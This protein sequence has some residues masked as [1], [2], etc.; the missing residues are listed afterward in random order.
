MNSDLTSR[1]FEMPELGRLWV[2][3]QSADAHKASCDTDRI[4]RAD[5]S[6]TGVIGEIVSEPS[7]QNI[8]PVIADL[9]F[10]AWK[11]EALRRGRDWLNFVASA[12]SEEGIREVFADLGAA[13]DSLEEVP[14]EKC[15]ADTH[16]RA[17]QK[18]EDTY[19][20]R[21]RGDAIGI[22]TGL[23]TLDRC[24]SG[25]FKPGELVTIGAL[26]GKGKTHIG[27]S[28][29]MNAIRSGF[30]ACY[31]TI[32]M[33]DIAIM[34]RMIAHQSGVNSKILTAGGFDDYRIDEQMDAV[35]RS[36]EP[37]MKK[38]LTIADETAG[39]YENLEALVRRLVRL[40]KLDILVI[41]Y[42]QQFYFAKP[43][44]NRVAELNLIT[45]KVKH[46]TKKYNFSTV[47]LAQ[48]NREAQ[49]EK[50]RGK[51]HGSHQF[52]QSHSIAK[53]SDIILIL[54]EDAIDGQ[55]FLYLSKNR[56]GE[57]GLRLPV[58][59]DRRVSRIMEVVK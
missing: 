54:D 56:N 34:N 52:E 59:L 42:I 25:G 26:T 37:F 50:E 39:V 35:A 14:T 38:L 58:N 4:L 30:K 20:A 41:D 7:Y 23:A 12:K 22:P 47:M 29:A 19:L 33:S 10:R 16:A 17:L 40:G 53:D 11:A 43:L 1:H 24:L 51:A 15:G 45:S 44:Q 3:L 28:L 27:V 21:K 9:K 32:E 48:L 36:A 5:Q 55:E 13:V 57:D 8:E 46:L 31:A 2:I 18:I 6:L 49:K